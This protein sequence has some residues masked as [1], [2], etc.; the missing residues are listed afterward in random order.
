MRLFV[1]LELPAAIRLALAAWTAALER[2]QLRPVAAE[3]LHVTLCFLGERADPAPIAA[4]VGAVSTA[5]PPLGEV[6]VAGARWLPRRHPRVLAAELTDPDG[7]LAALAR[8]VH[9]A[10]DRNPEPARFLPHV[11]VARVRERGLRPPGLAAAAIPP[12]ELGPA[13]LMR[14]HLG[15]GPARYERLAVWPIR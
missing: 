13:A 8:S 7:R 10:L 9:R 15:R 1:A 5:W 3:S 6:E 2:P 12:F 4:A 11:T 14:S